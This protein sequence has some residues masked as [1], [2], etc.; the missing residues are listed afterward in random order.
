MYRRK[1]TERKDALKS[2]MVRVESYVNGEGNPD[3]PKDTVVGV[4]FDNG[5]RVAISLTK[6]GE[7][8]SN[9]NRNTIESFTK[10]ASKQHV[11]PGGLIQFDTVWMQD[12]ELE[13]GKKGFARWASFFEKDAPGVEQQVSSGNCMFHA[14]VSVRDGGNEHRY[15]FVERL[16]K[17]LSLSMDSLEKTL[18]ALVQSSVQQGARARPI[19]RAM[20]EQGRILDYAGIAQRD[21]KGNDGNYRPQ[22][23]AEMM[24]DLKKSKAFHAVAKLI[25]EGKG[26]LEMLPSRSFQVSPKTMGS[27]RGKAFLGL[28]RVFNTDERR[29]AMNAWVRTRK[30]DEGAVFVSNI[31]LIDH[32][33]IDPLLLPSPKF[34]APSYHPDL[35]AILEKDVKNER[36]AYEPAPSAADQA[37][38]EPE[39]PGYD[40][41]MPAFA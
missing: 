20:D 13:G 24:A 11:E 7:A 17:P 30:T 32:Q 28:D 29:F 1:S 36:A 8:A 15:G 12:D 6:T 38:P 41:D 27:A 10:K 26:E 19:L 25:E 3:G 31:G 35:L 40:D 39:D 14:S 4:R 2:L 21:I 16:G 22:T 23:G 18:E 9:P 5:E 34:E 33:R 37:A